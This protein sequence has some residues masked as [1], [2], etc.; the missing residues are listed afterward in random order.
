M[1]TFVKN[2]IETLQFDLLSTF[3][4]I[5]HG[6]FTKRRGTVM[7]ELD[8]NVQHGIISD[9]IRTNLEHALEAYKLK[10]PI[11]ATQMH[12]DDILTI[13]HENQ[14]SAFQCDGFI[15]QCQDVTLLVKHADCQAAL[16]YDPT[17]QVIGNIHCGWKG[18]VLNIYAKTITQMKTVF[19]CNPKNIL[20]CISPSLGPKHA[21]FIHYQKEFPKSFWPYK[22]S[23]NRFDLW[24]ISEMQLLDAGILK[25][26]IE[27]AQCC[28]YEQKD[29][30][31][32]Y[33]RKDL[34]ARNLTYIAFK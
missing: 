21:E 23:K 6:V 28:T 2:K 33:R 17:Q 9:T 22:D 24:K 10:M 25:E 8:L 30:F 1:Q 31:F 12:Q 20:V 26:H 18:N 4:N 7:S 34:T 15:T 13:T 19:G 29:L 32:S 5:A 16:F 11:F 3:Q 27:I 14:N